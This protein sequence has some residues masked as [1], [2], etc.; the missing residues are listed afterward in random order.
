MPINE[1][2]K[3]SQFMNLHNQNLTPKI[4]AALCLLIFLSSCQK[5]I[6]KN[7]MSP[8]QGVSSHDMSR[9]SDKPN[10]ILITADDVGYEIPHYS[11]GESYST[12]NLDFMAA[13]GM[14]FSRFRPHP[15]GPPSRLALNTGK[16]NYRN[17]IK[18]GY[19]P[20]T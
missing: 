15:D 2:F 10:I 1:I 13:N 8:A 4:L 3:Y 14:Q 6:D 16:Y 17:W 7:V 18:F 9:Q 20:P 12:P 19:L 11:G 5:N